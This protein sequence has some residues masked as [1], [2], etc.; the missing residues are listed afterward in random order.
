MEPLDEPSEIANA[1]RDILIEI[2]PVGDAE[3]MGS[4]GHQLH[5]SDRAFRGT[6]HGR[7]FDSRST[8]ERTSAIGT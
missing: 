4:R 3:L 1:A 7:Q 8:I 5:E 2:A 6:A